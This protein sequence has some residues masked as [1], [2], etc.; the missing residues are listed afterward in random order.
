MKQN[1][2]ILTVYMFKCIPLK[3]EFICFRIGMRE[4]NLEYLQTFIVIQ[5]KLL[6]IVLT[7]FIPTIILNVIGHMSNYYREDFFEGLMAMNVTVMLV[8]TTLFLRKVFY[9]P[10]FLFDKYF[11]SV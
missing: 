2:Y 3:L 8:L 1:I 5:R 4:V 11:L 7:T 6:S 9:C 10:T